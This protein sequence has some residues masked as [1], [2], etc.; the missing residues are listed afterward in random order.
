MPQDNTTTLSPD[1]QRLEKLAKVLDTINDSLSK[2]EFVAALEKVG[3][4]I[5]Q[6]EQKNT[7]AIDNLEAIY[8]KLLTETQNNH[9]NSLSELKSK[10]NTAFVG[11][12]VAKMQQEHS[13]RMKEVSDKIA[14]VKDGK[15][16]AKGDTVVGPPGLDG[17][18][19]TPLDIIKKLESVPEKDKLVIEAIK[20]LREELDKLEKRI[21]K[22]I[23][24]GGGGSAGGGRIVK[25]YDISSSLNGV[26]K[27]F[28]LPAFWRVLSVQSSSF[29]NAFRPA[30][31]YTTDASAMTITFDAD[32]DAASTLATGQTIT[33]LYS[34]A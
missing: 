1:Q 28:A 33:V 12:I 32:I 5:L 31:D 9:Q 7:E 16:G 23:I 21:G 8:K 29:P 26:L 22:G 20:G 19:D 10:V 13:Q 25:I 4:I 17:S 24:Y 6:I 27:T 2:E 34:E 18:P 15:P 11:D 14:K 3:Q 30:V